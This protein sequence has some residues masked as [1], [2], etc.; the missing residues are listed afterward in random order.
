[1]GKTTNKTVDQT[2][3]RPALEITSK[4]DS[5]WRCGRQFF[6]SAP[7]LVPL[8]ELEEGQLDRLTQEPELVVKE[9][10]I[11]AVPAAEPK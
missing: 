9:V 10:E 7:V 3:P 4:R 11:P 8:D 5:F 1:M 6:R 2:K